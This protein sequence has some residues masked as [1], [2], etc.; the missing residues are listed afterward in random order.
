MA[1]FSMPSISSNAD[2]KKVYNYLQMLNQQLQYCF[3]GIDPEDNFSL[4]A[5]VKYKETDEAISQLEVSMEGFLAQFKNLEEQTE[6]RFSVMNN[7]IQMKVSADELCS[8]ISMNPGTINFKT[9]YITFD[10]KNFKLDINGV[11]QFSGA[12]TGGSININNN[13][14]VDSEGRATLK[15]MVYDGNVTVTGPC[16]AE[17]MLI[18]G[19]LSVDGDISCNNMTVSG[20]VTAE[21]YFQSSDR[22]LKE[23]IQV[24][25][26][27]QALSLV[28]GLRPV[29]YRYKGSG[30]EAMGFIAQ[31][32]NDLQKDMG[33]DMPLTNL[34]EDGYYAIDY[35]GYTALIA[36]AIKEQQKQL[37]ELERKLEEEG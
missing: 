31:E 21:E 13:F 14:I 18:G 10:T 2:M 25:P 16:H 5:L 27:E 36:G 7:Q 4:D 9:G 3:S 29:R 20:S 17:L 23:D 11:A 15:S 12:I 32:V 22:R 33:T 34:G 6:T 35:S 24:I 8:E 30:I 26:D 37:D 19:E 28:L 1:A